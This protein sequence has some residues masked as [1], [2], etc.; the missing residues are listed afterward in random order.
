MF[1]DV[2]GREVEVDDK[3][4]W[5][6]TRG[7]SHVE[8]ICG[9]VTKINRRS[10]TIQEWETLCGQQNICLPRGYAWSTAIPT[11]FDR[12]IIVENF[13]EQEYYEI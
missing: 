2:L 3:I 9:V 13:N 12:V 5:F 10:I 6:K 8:P 11:Q 4:V 1:T 7:Q